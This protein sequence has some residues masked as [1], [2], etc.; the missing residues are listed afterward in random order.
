M[1]GLSPDIFFTPIVNLLMDQ[2]LPREMQ[3]VLLNLY[4]RNIFLHLAVSRIF[5]LYE[6]RKFYSGDHVLIVR[7]CSDQ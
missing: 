6:N 7:L 4:L 2:T 1:S 3:I 5:S